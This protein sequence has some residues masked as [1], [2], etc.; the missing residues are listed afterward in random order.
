MGAALRIEIKVT[1]LHQHI[2]LREVK[3]PTVASKT[4]TGSV[5]TALLE[6]FGLAQ[7]PA[8]F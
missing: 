7:L 8:Y 2:V 5:Q 4:L 1:S 3:K 6:R